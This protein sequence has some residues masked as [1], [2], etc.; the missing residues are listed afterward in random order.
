MFSFLIFAAGFVL[1]I[2]SADF[3]IKGSSSIAKRLNVSDLI[4]GLTVVAFGTS[5]P[6]LTVNMFSA[7]D[8]N[9]DLA[10]GNI[11]GSNIAN[12]LLI[13]GISAMINPLTVKNNTIKIEIP[14][15]FLAVGILFVTMNDTLF[16]AS[17]VSVLSQN[18]GIVLL[19]FFV[20]FLYYVFFALKE[21]L[22]SLEPQIETEKQLSI[23]KTLIFITLGLAGLVIGGK[24]I[25]TN[26]IAIAKSFGVSEKLIGLSVVALGTSLPE[27]ATSAVAAYRKN[28]DI[29]VGNVVGSNIFNIFLI[30]GITPLI[31]PIP[32]TSGTNVDIAVAA[33][34]SLLLIFF[35]F[36]GRGK[37]I[38]RTEGSILLLCYVGYTIYIFQ[39]G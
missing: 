8:G 19:S 28:V 21:D 9:T 26:G 30:L 14:F 3:L 27:L 5:L 1:L 10:V 15:S 23:V 37:K 16:S 22:Q 4:V 39:R 7:I 24:L 33:F 35:V 13:L 2:G 29:A 12:I 38:D 31:S 18:D 25:V 32:L 36:R 20:I 17:T 34:S 11:V 6:E